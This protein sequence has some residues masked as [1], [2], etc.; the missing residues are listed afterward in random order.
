MALC[1]L[2]KSGTVDFGIYGASEIG[3]LLWAFI[4]E[5][6]DE[7]GFGMIFDDGLCDVFQEDGFS[8]ARWS[9]DECALAFSEGR[10]KVDGAGTDGASGRVFEDDA[11]VGVR[12]G[13]SVK[14]SGF[15]PFCGGHT[16]DGD[17]LFD[18]EEPFAVAWSAEFGFDLETGFE[19]E[20]AVDVEWHLDVLGDGTEVVSLP[21]EEDT[22]LCAD[23]GNGF[24]GQD[25][26]CLCVSGG[27]VD[28][29][30]VARAVGVEAEVEGFCELEEFDERCVVE[31]VDVERLGCLERLGI[32]L[33]GG[34]ERV[35]GD[36]GLRFG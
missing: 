33:G 13:E 6:D 29:E 9:D 27:D 1:V 14:V 23:V 3:D 2:V 24:G 25:G 7:G 4:H 32:L 36:S 10:D 30:V 17:D 21:A 18:G 12:G 8:C 22:S 11:L 31:L 34:F 16:F 5:Q 28:D 26:S 15:A 19:A 20:G 35:L